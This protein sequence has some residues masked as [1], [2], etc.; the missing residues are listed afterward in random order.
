[1]GDEA[2]MEEASSPVH[3]YVWKSPMRGGVLPNL[4]QKDWWTHRDLKCPVQSS[5]SERD[6]KVNMNYLQFYVEF[7]LP[8]KGL[9][10]LRVT[11]HRRHPTSWVLRITSSV[12]G[13]PDQRWELSFD[14]ASKL[15]EIVRFLS[16]LG[17]TESPG[18]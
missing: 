8:S 9:V 6:G 3:P 2:W 16:S 5:L 15:P 1:M 10:R 17:M 14:N 11:L 12:K 18:S 4:S 7:S 13:E